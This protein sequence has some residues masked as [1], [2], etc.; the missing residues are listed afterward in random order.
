MN[1]DRKAADFLL[2]LTREERPEQLFQPSGNAQTGL[3]DK[4]SSTSRVQDS[5]SSRGRCTCLIDK[6]CG[7]INS[8]LRPARSS[9]LKNVYRS[10]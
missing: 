2:L 6:S 1:T 4:Q 8:T 7:N 10:N 3:A 5:S 9:F